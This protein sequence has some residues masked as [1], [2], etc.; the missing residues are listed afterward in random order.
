MWPPKQA[1]EWR[2]RLREAIIINAWQLGRDDDP[3]DP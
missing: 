3:L 1:A 2:S